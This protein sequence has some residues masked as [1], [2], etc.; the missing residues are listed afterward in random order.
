MWLAV[1]VFGNT[2]IFYGWMYETAAG[3]YLNR[4]GKMAEI[5]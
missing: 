3:M 2:A 4:Y 1:H 5:S